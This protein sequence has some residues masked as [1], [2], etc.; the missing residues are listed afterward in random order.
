MVSYGWPEI[1]PKLRDLRD[2]GAWL[3]RLGHFTSWYHARTL[4]WQLQWKLERFTVWGE[5]ASWKP[6]V[7]CASQGGSFDMVSQRVF[8]RFLDEQGVPYIVICQYNDDDGALGSEGERQTAIG[9]LSRRD[10]SRS[11]RSETCAAAERQIAAGLPN[12]CVVRNPVNLV[13]FRPVPYPPKSDVVTMANVARLNVQFKGQDVLLEA[14][15]GDAGG[16]A[17]GCFD[18]TGPAPTGLTWSGWRGTM[19]SAKRSSSAGTSAT[20]DPSGPIIICS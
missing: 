5:L 15:G 2:R 19:A 1:P 13:D 14:L 9:Y 3:L 18:S 10:G 6:D 12:A 4:R 16:T 17:P 8:T 7:V 20:S 11:W